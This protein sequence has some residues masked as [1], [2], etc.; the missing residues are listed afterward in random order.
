ML[1]RRIIN[2]QYRQF[3]RYISCAVR[4]ATIALTLCFAQVQKV[5]MSILTY[6]SI[7]DIYRLHVCCSSRNLTCSKKSEKG[8][9]VR[10]LCHNSIY[11]VM[12]IFQ[13]KKN[14]EN[15]DLEARKQNPNNE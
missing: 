12:V 2:V 4:H 13:F 11:I 6:R 1:A 3:W 5:G 14:L 10:V 9:G 7:R 8:E 15:R